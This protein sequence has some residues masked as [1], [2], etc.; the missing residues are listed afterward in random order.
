LS[1]AANS[2]SIFFGSVIPSRFGV[3][4]AS[5]QPRDNLLDQLVDRKSYRRQPATTMTRTPED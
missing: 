5:H 4:I 1:S 3:A 2:A